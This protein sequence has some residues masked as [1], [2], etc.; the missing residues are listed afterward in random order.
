MFIKYLLDFK[1]ICFRSENYSVFWNMPADPCCHHGFTF[2]EAE[3]YGFIKNSDNQFKGDKIVLLYSPGAFPL[4]S[5]NQSTDEY[6]AQNGGLPQKG[7]LEYHLQ[8]LSEQIN[9]SIPDPD[10]DGE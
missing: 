4:L 8:I 5:R 3:T 6:E 9:S 1:Y 2:P 10:F 7:D